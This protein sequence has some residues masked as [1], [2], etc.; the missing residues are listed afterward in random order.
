MY[1]RTGAFKTSLWKLAEVKGTFEIWVSMYGMPL[2]FP[3]QGMGRTDFVPEA[4]MLILFASK[5]AERKKI[6]HLILP[7]ISPTAFS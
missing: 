2:G 6:E 7:G 5:D 4:S 3:K 1:A